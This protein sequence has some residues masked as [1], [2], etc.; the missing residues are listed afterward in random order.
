MVW[1]LNAS[2]FQSGGTSVTSQS[3][4][5]GSRTFSA[6]GSVS[7]PAC[8][9][10]TQMPNRKP[11]LVRFVGDRRPGRGETS[12]DRDTSR[13]HRGTIRHRRETF[14]GRA[15]CASRD[16]AQGKLFVDLHAAA[17]AVVDRERIVRIVPRVRDCRALCAPRGAADWQRHP[18]RRRMRRERRWEF[19]TSSPGARRVRNGPGSGLRP[20]TVE[21]CRRCA[22]ARCGFFR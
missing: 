21:S 19:R 20:S 1:P 4:T 2:G 5:L 13:R 17:P 11:V 7:S 22:E 15:V 18:A 10:S 6:P 16:H 14:P 9:Q 3:R 8:V 12:A